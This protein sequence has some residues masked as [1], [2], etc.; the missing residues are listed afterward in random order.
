MIV[1]VETRCMS[2]R[3]CV[4]H[5]G[6]VLSINYDVAVQHLHLGCRPS[7]LINQTSKKVLLDEVIG[8]PAMVGKK[9]VTIL[10][11]GGSKNGAFLPCRNL[12]SYERCS[13]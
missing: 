3:P 6:S 10:E 5:L 8:R 9:P 13:I 12:P 1:M 2:A 4:S 7:S 11:T